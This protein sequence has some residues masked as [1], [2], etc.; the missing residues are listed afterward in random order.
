ISTGFHNVL[1]AAGAPS[2]L[3]IYAGAGHSDFLF[4][5]LTEEQARVVRDIAGFVQS[6]GR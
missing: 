1:Q 2:T 5:A 6:C 3:T 4:A